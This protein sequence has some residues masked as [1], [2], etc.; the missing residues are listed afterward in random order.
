M[1]LIYR[2]MLCF[3]FIGT[4]IF[5]VSAV[6][7]AQLNPS[8][9]K[10]KSILKISKIPTLSLKKLSL[11]DPERF[12][13]RNQYSMSFSSTSGSGSL[14]GTYINTMEYHFNAPLIMR[15]KVAYQSGTNNLF[16][17]KNMYSGNPN[18]QNGRLFIPSFDIVYK[19]WKNMT[20]SFIYRD[21]SSYNQN[22]RYSRSRF[23][24][25]MRY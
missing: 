12:T 3:I 23:S 2:R 14:I 18:N 5:S 1:N 16:G 20:V 11:L 6:A 8:I 9:N 17:N 22:N 25:L 7:Y 21:Y 13:M 24:P 10:S 15:L 4:F 19:P